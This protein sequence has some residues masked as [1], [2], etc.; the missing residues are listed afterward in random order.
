MSGP[1]NM[2]EAKKQVLGYCAS[3]LS[4]ELMGWVEGE[5]EEWTPAQL[6]RYQDAVQWLEDMLRKKAEKMGEN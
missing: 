2:K 3:S 5:T 1:K 6:K 4:D